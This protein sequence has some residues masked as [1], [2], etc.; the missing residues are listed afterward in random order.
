MSGLALRIFLVLGQDLVISKRIKLWERKGYDKIKK[1][2]SFQ[3]MVYVYSGY[4]HKTLLRVLFRWLVWFDD[5]TTTK[6][7]EWMNELDVR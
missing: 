5:G 6:R 7:D 1:T 4:V 3:T 2:N